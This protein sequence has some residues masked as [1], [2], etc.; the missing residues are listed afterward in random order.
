[1]NGIV[2]FLESHGYSILFAAVFVRQI[3]L[4]VP[5][6]LFLV[7]AGALAAAGK[8]LLFAAIALALIA[9]VLADWLWYEAGRCGGDK[10]LHFI[11]R[12]TRDPEFHD[13]RAKAIFARYGLPLL[14]IAKFVPGLDAIAPPMAGASHTSRLTFLS[15]EA[16]G[17]CLY[18]C[19]YGG[20]GYV[21]SHDLD[22]ALTYVSQA[23]NLLLGLALAGIGISIG[24]KLLRRLRITGEQPRQLAPAD[25]FECGVC[26]DVPSGILGGQENGE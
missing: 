8:L 5:G 10:V 16:V 15:F 9:C 20:L 2:Q 22:R 13:R 18:S 11:H 7:A 14:V 21:F 4:P 1:M 26:G 12:F 24:V 19:V 23:R 17:A 3:G 6:F 25:P